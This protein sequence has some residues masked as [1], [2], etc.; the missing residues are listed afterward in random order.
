M[1]EYDFQMN[2][3]P[4]AKNIIINALSRATVCSTNPLAANDVR[5][6]DH[7]VI[8]TAQ[9]KEYYSNRILQWLRQKHF[10]CGVDNRRMQPFHVVGGIM[11][12]FASRPDKETSSAFEVPTSMQYELLRAAHAHHYSGHEG[13]SITAAYARKIMVANY[14]GGC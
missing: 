7:N 4:A 3:L 6:F 13:T 9:S 11:H 12:H 14:D 10:L 5:T 8:R 1:G 2:F